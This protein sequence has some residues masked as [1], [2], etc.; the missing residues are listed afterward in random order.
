M[1]NENVKSF[2]DWLHC[3]LISLFKNYKWNK[4]IYTNLLCIL[5]LATKIPK[6]NYNYKI[7]VDFFFYSNAVLGWNI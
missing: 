1:S 7:Y 6:F 3:P 5:N 2:V 4:V